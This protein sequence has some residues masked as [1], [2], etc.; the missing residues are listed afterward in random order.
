[1]YTHTPVNQ[2]YPG[3]LS[4][5]LYSNNNF[6]PRLQFIDPMSHSV[7]TPGTSSTLESSTAGAGEALA[8]QTDLS[9]RPS[10]VSYMNPVSESSFSTQQEVVICFEDNTIFRRTTS[11]NSIA[12]R[13][14]KSSVWKWV[15]LMS[16]H[17]A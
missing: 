16:V 17:P 11:S 14:M 7:I 12:L 8:Q 13:T 9:F 3:P 2:M 5:P 4:Q 15:V 6:T 10:S 1:M